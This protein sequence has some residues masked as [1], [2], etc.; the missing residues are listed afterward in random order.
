MTE[1]RNRVNPGG[2]S[3]LSGG[4]EAVT[5]TVRAPGFTVIGPGPTTVSRALDPEAERTWPN[6][7]VK[8]GSTPLHAVNLTPP[9]AKLCDSVARTARTTLL[10]A[11]GSGKLR[12]FVATY[13]AIVTP[14]ALSRATR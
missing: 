7:V 2:G 4:V 6:A 9:S 5:A 11:F 3:R 10:S 1:P 12:T 8:L 14:P 13:V